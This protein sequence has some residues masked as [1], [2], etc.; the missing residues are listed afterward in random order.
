MEISAEKN[1]ENIAPERAGGSPGLADLAGRK[2]WVISDGRAGHLAITLGIAEALGVE[3]EVKPVAPRW[4]HRALAPWGPAERRFIDELLGQPWPAIAL[5]AGRQTVPVIRALKRRSGGRIFTVIGQDPKTG[6]GSADVIWVPQHDRLRG[7]N[8]VATL[9]PPHRYSAA[10]LTHLRLDVHPEIAQRP[11]PYCAV[12]VGGPGGGYAWTAE[13][14]ARFASCLE[15]MGRQTGS[16]LITPSRRTPPELLRAVDE[17][18]AGI[19]RWLWAGEGENPYPAFLAHADAFIVTAD[20][21]NMAGEASATGRSIHVFHPQGG[22]PKFR[23]YHRALEAHGATRPLVDG[24][25]PAKA[26]AY[27][28]LDAATEVAAEII[29]R[30]RLSPAASCA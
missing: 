7:E 24:A 22:R 1:A 19:P 2:A 25:L 5:G 15:S 27:A 26:W 16:F 18:T 4:P 17:A 28:P 21:V 23:A 13:D 11:G 8:V 14:I 12:F 3:A 10:R 6:P 9:T 20:S 29:S 30:W